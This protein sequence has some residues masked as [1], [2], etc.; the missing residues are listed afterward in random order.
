MCACVVGKG[1]LMQ[2]QSEET[3]LDK[4]SEVQYFTRIYYSANVVHTTI[5][6]D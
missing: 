2:T 5:I 1:R 4:N 6:Y 3:I